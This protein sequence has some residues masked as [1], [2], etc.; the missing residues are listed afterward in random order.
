MSA[1]KAQQAVT[2]ARRAKC[3]E[4]RLAGTRYVV[5]A[6]ELGYADE[7]SARR[8]FD[9]ALTASLQGLQSS[10]DEF[11]ALELERLDRLQVSVWDAAIG[12]DLRAVE[13]VLKIMNSRAKLLGLEAPA[14]M[15]LSIESIDQ[16]IAETRQRLAVG[17][18]VPLAIEAARAEPM[19][20]ADDLE[21]IDAEIMR[22]REKIADE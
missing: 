22:L 21:A 6:V 7:H 8:D 12:G 10:A 13:V 5:I 1:S 4:L 14:R 19:T 20:D 18:S 17:V 15:E 9:R 16:Q 2:A 3:I 11:R